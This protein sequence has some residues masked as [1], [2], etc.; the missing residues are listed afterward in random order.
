M[1][2]YKSLTA[3]GNAQDFD[4]TFT[5]EYEA[6]QTNATIL[7]PT[8]GT[9]LAIKG[10]YIATSA[11][12][13]ELRLIIDGNTISVT[14]AVQQPGYVPL[15]ITGLRNSPLKCT[16]VFGGVNYFVSVNYREE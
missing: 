11:T 3:I 7:T 2:N 6:D 15:Y 16:A 13:G 4:T 9:K 12:S 5:N 10:V 14:Y 8:S 1:S